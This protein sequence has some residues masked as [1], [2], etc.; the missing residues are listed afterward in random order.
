MACCSRRDATR[1]AST[2]A[3]T[4]TRRAAD[5]R[6][7]GLRLAARR[8]CRRRAARGAAVLD[9]AAVAGARRA[10]PA[11]WSPWH[12]YDACVYRGGLAA[13]A[14]ASGRADRA[15]SSH[16]AGRGRRACSARRPCAGSAQRS[17]GIYLWHWPVMALTRPGIDVH[18]PRG[19]C[20]AVPDRGDGGA[21]RRLVP[22]GGAADPDRRGARRSALARRRAPA[23]AARRRL[24]A[25]AA[26]AS[27][28][29]GRGRVPRH[30]AELPTLPA[31][32]AALGRRA[33]RDARPTR[34]G[35]R[36][37]TAAERRPPLAVGASVMLAA[38]PELGRHATVDAAVGRQ[39]QDIIGRLQ[40]YR[41][42]AS[43][44]SRVVVQIGENGPVHGERHPPRCGGVLRGVARVVH[45]QR[46][47]SRAAGASV[48]S[49][50][51]PRR[52]T[53]WPEA[54]LA[55]WYDAAPG[56]ACSTTTSRTPTRGPEGL[57]ADRRAG[58]RGRVTQPDQAGLPIPM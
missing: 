54:R 4:R 12:D 34:S 30:A 56:R 48:R 11:R 55:D 46:R 31:E 52:S 7:A 3:P 36:G 20:V 47:A 15:P 21:R 1:R 2:T 13:V 51:S 43:C 25:L 5:R 28:V 23:A 53:R 22:L 40:A 50:R 58:A 44:P 16:P 32:R 19:C 24:A 10:G 27:R 18:W 57:H 17:Y 41:A 49:T 33:T 45:R 35:R 26:A 42:R 39:A 29:A 37:G 38:Q 6:A 9:G 8:G 14:V